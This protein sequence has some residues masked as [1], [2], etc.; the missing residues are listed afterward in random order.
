M[1]QVIKKKYSHNLYWWILPCLSL[2]FAISLLQNC[3]ESKDS[4]KKASPAPSKSD[5]TTEDPTC[6][7][8]EKVQTKDDGTKECVKEDGTSD[9]CAADEYAQK[10]AAGVEQCVKKPT[11][12]ATQELKQDESG[13]YVCSPIATPTV[14]PFTCPEGQVVQTDA[15]GNQSCVTPPPGYTA[16]SAGEHHTCAIVN[17][18]GIRCWGRNNYGQIGNNTTTDQSSPVSVRK[19]P[20]HDELKNVT[21]ISIGSWHSC[22]LSGGKVY[23]WGYNGNGQL[24]DNTLVNKLDGVEV[25]GLEGVTSIS[26]GGAHSCAV[27]SDK[28]VQCW[29]MGTYGQLGD[30]SGTSYSTPIAVT[31]VSGV[32]QIS[33]GTYHT[34]ALKEDGTVS[35]WGFNKFGQLGTGDTNNALYPKEVKLTDTIVLGEV[36][37]ISAGKNGHYVDANNLGFDATCAVKNDGKVWCW[38]YGNYGLL[39]NN[40]TVSIYRPVQVKRDDKGD[41]TISGDLIEAVS[42]SVGG[43]HAC[44]IVGVERVA[45]C[46]GHNSAYAIGD[47]YAADRKAAVVLKGMTVDG[48]Q[49]P[50]LKGIKEIVAAGGAVDGASAS[51]MFSVAIFTDGLGASWGLNS[52]GNLG[53]GEPKN[54]RTV[55]VKILVP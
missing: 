8:G 31:G 14:T 46:W 38:G 28:N 20:S 45:R 11:C 10:D 53:Q 48:V 40:N 51:L 42:V 35:C 43:Y 2:C 19:S 50:Q 5:S 3:G 21:A 23:C 30:S 16:I 47:G 32:T 37:F 13:Q 29:G 54:N 7:E 52:Y 55:P 17:D 1:H 49:A 36:K 25:M 41:G 18:G 26:A 27:L 4:V 22:A 34:C 39:G 6:A 33:C 24:G 12:T 9:S 15:A 44:A